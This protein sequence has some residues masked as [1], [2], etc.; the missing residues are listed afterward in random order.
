MTSEPGTAPRQKVQGPIALSVS[1]KWTRQGDPVENFAYKKMS[2]SGGQVFSYD[3]IVE[4]QAK[5][6]S[7]V[8]WSFKLN[9][10]PL[11]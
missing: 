2:L 8:V 5:Q 3:L 4:A 10:D 1:G 6:A 11:D 7:R 9:N